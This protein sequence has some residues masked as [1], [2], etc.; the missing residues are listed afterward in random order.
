MSLQQ[1][2]PHA[3]HSQEPT[4]GSA[5]RGGAGAEGG[6]S[7]GAPGRGQVPSMQRGRSEPPG[8]S[9]T[10]GSVLAPLR[11]VAML[12]CGAAAAPFFLSLL[13]DPARLGQPRP[14]LW[15]VAFTAF[16]ALF[17]LPAPAA[18]SA[19]A[20]P[21]TGPWDCRRRD[22]TVLAVQAVL[23]VALVYLVPNGIFGVFLVIVAAG[24]GEI[25]TLPVAA[26][27]VGVQT[28]A[29]LPVFV[30]LSSWSGALGFLG[31]FGGFQLFAAFAAHAAE[32]E[33]RARR[34]LAETNAELRATRELL[35]ETSRSAERLRIARDLHDVLG[36]HL[37]ALSLNL[38]AA[39]HAEPEQSA[40]H[41]ET[42]RAL[43]RRLLSEV[44]R[45]VG[46]LR[47]DDGA[48]TDLAS[49]LAALGEGIDRPRLHVEVPEGL[50]RLR[51]PERSAV[52]L[53]CAQEMVTNAVRHSA[54]ENLWLE[55]SRRDG[56]G[57]D[58]NL[59]FTARDDGAGATEA[60]VEPGHGLTGM[61]ERLE[62]FGG[63]LSFAT[64]P[65]GGFE[66]TVWLP[67]AAG[68]WKPKR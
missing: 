13:D 22:L 1:A 51:D 16:I 18:A 61:R 29:L 40:T 55:L 8:A 21:A 60:D 56:D 38:E 39:R 30:Q 32:S 50:R 68:E 42:A 52:L 27:W 23:A 43:T 5:P 3:T 67:T 12:T 64:G 59:V 36:H 17:W 48:A 31:A 6:P 26:L 45:V 47:D 33:R 37:T 20:R 24:L 11:W 46:R 34:E 4:P 41:V 54:A 66:V 19:A 44:R 9:P 65:G 62:S 28:L 53:R 7:H 35:A 14:I 15:L 2:H 57:R 25:F 10:A 63:R 58:G 49:A